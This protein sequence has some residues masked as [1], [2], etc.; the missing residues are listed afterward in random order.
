MALVLGYVGLALFAC[1]GF[2][3]GGTALAL[4]FGGAV[5]T[6]ASLGV[7]LAPRIKLARREKERRP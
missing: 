1:T 7:G 2:F 5:L 6:L 3:S 4:C